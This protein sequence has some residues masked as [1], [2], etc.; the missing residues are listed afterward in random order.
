MKLK[1][2]PLMSLN[3]AGQPLLLL[4]VA[5]LRTLPLPAFRAFAVNKLAAGLD[6]EWASLMAVRNGLIERLGTDGAIPPESPNMAEFVKE[7]TALGE[8]E[9]TLPIT[10][11]IKLPG[12]ILL[13][14]A[15]L[16]ALDPVCEL[17][18][19]LESQPQPK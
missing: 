16:A 11:K 17:E 8:M 6:A 9:F 14:G 2:Q 1:L 4:A 15:E 12:S 19:E 5:K 3:A 7:M 10:A 13:S 18:P